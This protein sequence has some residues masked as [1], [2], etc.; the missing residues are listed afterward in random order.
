MGQL[1]SS[2]LQAAIDNYLSYLD[3]H[4]PRDSSYNELPYL[5]LISLF[6]FVIFFFSDHHRVCFSSAEGIVIF[7]YLIKTNLQFKGTLENVVYFISLM[8]VTWLIKSHQ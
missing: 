4:F 8:E 2:T 7:V 3:I 1:I 5:G 6:D